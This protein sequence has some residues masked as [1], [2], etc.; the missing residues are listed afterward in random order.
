MKKMV[1]GFLVCV[2]CA[3]YFCLVVWMATFGLGLIYNKS[4][5]KPAPNFYEYP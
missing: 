3:F 1:E 2:L 5:E 4:E